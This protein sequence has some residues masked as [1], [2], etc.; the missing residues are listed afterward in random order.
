[1]SGYLIMVRDNNSDPMSPN[2]VLSTHC[3]DLGH[4]EIYLVKDLS[5]FKNIVVAHRIINIELF[6]VFLLKRCS[7][8]KKIPE[9][10]SWDKIK[11]GDELENIHHLYYIVDSD[12]YYKSTYFIGHVY[13]IPKATKTKYGIR[14]KGDENCTI[15]DTERYDFNFNSLHVWLTKSEKSNHVNYKI[16]NEHDKYC[17][18]NVVKMQR[19]LDIPEDDI[20]TNP[21][22]S[23]CGFI[24]RLWFMN[25]VVRRFNASRSDDPEF[26][27]ERI[28]VLKKKYSI[29]HTQRDLKSIRKGIFVY[30]NTHKMNKQ[31]CCK[32]AKYFEEHIGFLLLDA[33]STVTSVDSASTDVTVDSK[34]EETEKSKNVDDKTEKKKLKRAKM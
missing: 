22:G 1:M 26:I 21:L 15:Q 6:K 11:I 13:V 20:E 29:D 14:T 18:K 27:R 24:S 32:D 25:D 17:A 34:K 30:A 2:I 16:E 33:E 9:N 19:E 12:S 23:E 4:G 3:A 8:T 31:Q 7:K 5:K 10:T 28:D